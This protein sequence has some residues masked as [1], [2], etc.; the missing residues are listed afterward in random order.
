MKFK[1]IIDFSENMANM[2]KIVIVA[3]LDG[4][5]QRKVQIFLVQPVYIDYIQFSFIANHILIENLVYFFNLLLFFK[6]FGEILHLVP[7]AESVVK[8]RAVCMKCYNDA[9]FTKRITCDLQVKWFN[10]NYDEY[11]IKC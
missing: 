3:A 2:G 8:L 9:S 7:L 10:L 6:V 4:T 5:Y 11:F 1:D